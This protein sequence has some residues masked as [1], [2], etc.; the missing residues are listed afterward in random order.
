VAGSYHEIGNFIDSIGKL[1][2]I[3][4]VTDISMTNPKTQNQKIIVQSKFNIKTY[5]FVGGTGG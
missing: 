5:R 3:I 4:N 2:R 1:D